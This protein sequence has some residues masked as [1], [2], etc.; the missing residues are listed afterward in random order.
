[1][2]VTVSCNC[3]PPGQDVVTAAAS[4]HVPAAAVGV[5]E[6]EGEGDGPGLADVVYETGV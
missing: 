6:A 5:C 2:F 1:V 3:Y 4:A